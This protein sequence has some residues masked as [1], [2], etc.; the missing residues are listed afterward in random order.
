MEPIILSVAPNGAR[1]TTDDHPNIP[2][3]TEAIA[4]QAASWCEAGANLLH[5][6]IRDDQQ[7][8]TLDAARY[9]ETIAA[10]RATAGEELIIQ[11]TSEAVGIYQPEEQMQMVRSLEPEAVS[12][13]LREFLPDEA[14]E[15]AFGIFLKEV[16]AR[17][18]FPQYILYSPEEIAYFARLVKRQIIPGEQHF[19]LF[20]LGKKTAGATPKEA[21]AKPEDLDPFL[22]AFAEHGT[23]AKQ[24]WAVC[25]FG[26]YELDCMHKAIS[27]G[28]HVRIG[29]ENN[30]LLTDGSIAEDN[31]ALLRQFTESLTNATSRP[32]ATPA[33]A[34]TL[35]GLG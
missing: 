34:R 24:H 22:E 21:F 17:G 8:H 35:L 25:A 6:H 23:P 7:H 4:T 27:C 1:K 5:L 31:T 26:G 10:I 19:L 33:Q 18:V 2:V 32:L 13:A 3:T 28:G 14:Y 11:A 15:V 12:I 9:R 20:V 16:T 29:F 30:H